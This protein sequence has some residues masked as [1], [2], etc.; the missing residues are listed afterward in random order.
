[1]KGNTSFNN[2]VD[3]INYTDK[4]SSG[5]SSP[6]KLTIK[7]NIFFAKDSIQLILQISL[8]SN[9]TS[10]IGTI[11]SN[12]Y[13]RPIREPS[14]VDTKGYS[15]CCAPSFWPSYNDGG[16]ADIAIGTEH[17]KSLDKWQTYSSQD[18]HTHK[19]PKTITDT[20]D[21]RFEY[22]ASSTN[23]TIGLGANYIDVIGKSYPGT[24]TLAPYSSAV[25]IKS[26]PITNQP[27]KANAGPDQTI[28]L[29]SNSIILS[30]SGTDPN[31]S[32]SSYL[33][34]KISGPAGSSITDI[35][36]AHTSVTGLMKGVYNFELKVTD[37][38][39][40]TG[41]DTMQ[42]TVNAA[43]T[44]AAPP[45]AN[46]GSDIT[47]TLPDNTTLLAGSGNVAN[48]TIVSYLW[49]KISGP[50]SGTITN[51][52][53]A[54]A[55]AS[56]LTQGVYKFELKV[57]DN[58]GA[59][60]KD[61]VQVKVNTAFSVAV[62]HIA[63]AGSDITIT[64]PDNTT[65]LAG[66]GNVT[67]GTIVSY[68][69]TKIA[70]PATYNTVNASSAVTDISGLVEGVYNFELKVTDN[71]GATAKDTVQVT[72]NAANYIAPPVANA[73]SDITITL[74]DNTTSLTGSGS[75][76]NGTIVSYLWTKISGPATYNIAN[77]SSPVTGISELVQGVYNF[78]LEVTDN[79]GTTGKDTVQVTVNSTAS[80]AAP[81]AKAAPVANAG[82][83]QTIKLPENTA[84]LSGSGTDP[85]GTITSYSWKQIS[86]PSS[87][88]IVSSNAPV[89]ISINLVKGAYEFE[90]T[91]T[92]N[93][94][95]IGKDSVLV[96]VDVAGSDLDVQGNNIKIYPNPVVGMTTLEI[97]TT[98]AHSKLLVI[99]TNMQGQIVYKN[100][101]VSEE[102]TIRDK[103][104]MNSL[105]NSTYAVTVYFGNQGRQTAK[106][107][108]MD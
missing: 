73:G 39:G 79:N 68:L 72:V 20:R 104:N 10:S 37:N 96:V 3:Q 50:S 75:V 105:P 15:M 18:A 103:I 1:M 41:K 12:Y 27:P 45:V 11:D 100:E 88:G 83:D 30:G 98:H 80:I 87:S 5:V 66:S 53:S 81:V 86:G 7:N 26:G 14:N 44:I 71:N 106:I 99:I 59:T 21:I 29:P 69:W 49:A 101:L 35:D 89:A 93:L 40:L 76:A 85:D 46:A 31:G 32:I 38:N 28:I 19:S 91:V 95:A 33:W 108:K 4:G 23:K 84:L 9:Y 92:D 42:V 36:S 47:I 6:S 8:A 22:N 64:L 51:A 43:P 62:P 97:N 102:N 2:G 77:A 82:P 107:E 65:L 13:C 56:S 24:I 17:F 94:G 78:E 67:N 70:G 48:G 25:L 57:T 55:T 61:T 52:N 58:N 60:A 34:T 16:I 90:L 63:N 74:P 54:S